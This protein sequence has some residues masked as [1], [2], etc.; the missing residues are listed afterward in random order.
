MG[1][2]VQGPTGNYGLCNRHASS[3]LS[4]LRHNVAV[5]LFEIRLPSK[6]QDNLLPLARGYDVAGCTLNAVR[7][8][9]EKKGL[10][11]QVS[12]FLPTGDRFSRMI[13]GPCRTAELGRRLA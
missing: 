5:A 10:R 12:L 11:V 6:G 1:G 7:L 2:Q 9:G 8:I 4:V 13:A 3:T